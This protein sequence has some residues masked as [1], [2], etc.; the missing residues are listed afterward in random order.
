MGLDL[1]D[2]MDA[3][4][5]EL[6][7]YETILPRLT[8][9]LRANNMHEDI[10]A[11]TIYVSCSKKAI[12]FEDLSVKGY[13]MAERNNGMDMTH[14]RMVLRKLAIFHAAN[15]VLQEQEPQIFENF[16]HGIL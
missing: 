7:M 11:A 1:L 8:K 15:A 3:Y 4:D 9:L 10:F 5:K 13:R 14:S 12:V 6:E 16:K 2:E